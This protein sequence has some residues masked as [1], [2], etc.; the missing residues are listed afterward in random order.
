MRVSLGKP[1]HMSSSGR[2]EGRKTIKGIVPICKPK[3]P[4][5]QCIKI[6]HV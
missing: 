1:E 2:I 4:R 6:E 5:S 3:T